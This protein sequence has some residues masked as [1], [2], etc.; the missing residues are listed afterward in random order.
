M[1]PSASGEVGM[2]EDLV[3]QTGRRG[4]LPGKVV[5]KVDYAA[6]CQGHCATDEE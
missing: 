5:M 1:V 2:L 6:G 3:V 4:R